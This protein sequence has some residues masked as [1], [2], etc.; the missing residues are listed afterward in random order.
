[1]IYKIVA[2]FLKVYTFY[3]IIEFYLYSLKK[4]H[5]HKNILIIQKP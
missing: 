5:L 3:E 4:H 2:A 1:M